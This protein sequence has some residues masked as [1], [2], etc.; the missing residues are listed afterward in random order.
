ME[1]GTNTL[2]GFFCYFSWRREVSD[3]HIW[4]YDFVAE[5]LILLDRIEIENDATLAHQ[6]FAIGE[7]YG[8]TTE[9]REPTSGRL[10]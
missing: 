8:L 7:K 2:R 5:L 3:D 9:L 6:R 1:H 10:Q 4:P